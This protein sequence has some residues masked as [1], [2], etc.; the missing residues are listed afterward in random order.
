MDSDCYRVV[1]ASLYSRDKS[2]SSVAVVVD[3]LRDLFF[4]CA[5]PFL[6]PSLR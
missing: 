5:S 3:F 2:H 4:T 1:L 6:L